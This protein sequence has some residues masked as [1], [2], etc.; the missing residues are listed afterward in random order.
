VGDN[1]QNDI[2]AAGKAGLHTVWFN[3]KGFE[4]PD[5]EIRPDCIV[6]SEEELAELLL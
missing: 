6:Y 2:I 4:L 5:E 1:Y 3:R